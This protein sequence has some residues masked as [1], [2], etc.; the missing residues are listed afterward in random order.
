M[1][2]KILWK[3]GCILYDGFER[4]NYETK[5]SEDAAKLDVNASWVDSGLTLAKSVLILARSKEPNQYGDIECS[6]LTNC[7]TYI[8]NDEGKTIERI[9]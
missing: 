4:I 6:I 1:I 9:N 2:I 8:L 5:N 7:V 3:N